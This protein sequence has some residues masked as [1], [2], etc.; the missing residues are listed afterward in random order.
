MDRLLL[1]GY[2]GLLD[3]GRSWRD[4]CPCKN[5]A[6]RIFIVH[7]ND[8]SPLPE[9]SHTL[10]LVSSTLLL[11]LR[12]V[13][14]SQNISANNRIQLL[15]QLRRYRPDRDRRGRYRYLLLGHHD[16]CSSL[17]HCPVV[18]GH[19]RKLH[20]GE[21]RVHSTTHIDDQVVR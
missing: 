9:R 5:R 20:G 4:V 3:D 17:Y 19:L 6:H 18:F 2:Y 8:S 12:Q 14:A 21:V 1:D 7:T 13:R 16:A 10:Q 15:V 11:A